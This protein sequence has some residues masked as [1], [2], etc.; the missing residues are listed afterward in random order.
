MSESK[1]PIKPPYLVGILAWAVPGAGHYCLGMRARGV[2]IALAVAGLFWTGVAI[3]GVR[4]T[5]DP[6]KNMHWFLGEICTGGHAFTA[7]AINRMQ[8]WPPNSHERQSANKS[9][10]LGVVFAGVAGLLNLLVIFDAV[11][12]SIAGDVREEEPEDEDGRPEA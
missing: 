1:G 4:T 2:I 9:R 10:D 12:R 7:L 8:D 6:A 11:L 5:V 3:G